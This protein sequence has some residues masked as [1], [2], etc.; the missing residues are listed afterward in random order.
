M[1]A[2]GVEAADNQVGAIVAQLKKEGRYDDALIVLTADHGESFTER[3]LWFDHGTFP[4]EEQLHVPL[5]IKMPKRHQSGYKIDDL[6]AF[7][8]ILPTVLDVLKIDTPSRVTGKSLLK[9]DGSFSSS[10]TSY[11]LGESSHCKKEMTLQCDPLGPEGKV[12]S[13]RT[14]DQSMW[15][16][17]EAD[18]NA[19]WIFNSP[20][21]AKAERFNAQQSSR[22]QQQH[23]EILLKERS[24]RMESLEAIE[25]PQKKSDKASDSNQEAQKEKDQDITR[26]EELELLKQLGYIDDE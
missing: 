26:E 2:R 12:F 9:P 19:I 5:L 8:D 6:V 16:S 10:A 1:Y 14:P 17:A 22:A 24:T 3:D 11:L 15:L 25:W 23:L 13:L 4:S 21:E 7:K 20:D 18:K